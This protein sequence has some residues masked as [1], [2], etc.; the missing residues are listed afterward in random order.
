[1]ESPPIAAIIIPTL[2]EAAHI[3]PL[4]RQIIRQADDRVVE[5]IV[6]D[7]GSH[8]GTRRI[9]AAIGRE[10]PRVR[11]IDNLRRTQS[12]GL[13]IA[14]AVADP[15]ANV[16]V[17][18]DAHGAY[19]DDFVPRLLEA[20]VASG[21]QSVVIPMISVGMSCFQRAVAAVSNSVF[22]TGG[23]AHRIGGTSR[24]IDHGHHAAFDRRAFSAVGGYDE[25]FVANEDAELDVRLRAAGGR[26]WFASDIEMIY[27]PRSTA[28]G[29]AR[30][31]YNYGRGRA[32]TLRKHGERPR[33]RQLLPPVA[34]TA[35]ALALLLAPARPIALVVPAGYLAAVAAIAALLA[36]RTRDRCALA[37]VVAL[38]I[39]HLLWAAG[40]IGGLIQ[41]RAAA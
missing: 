5:I 41:P 3:E 16:L 24:F 1:M 23:A 12:A 35:I 6:A 39:I 20:L 2:N 29:L 19:P 9:V 11:L 7:G 40:L 36:A 10:E 37:A 32:R 18:I 22:G 4:L 25:S 13:N 26:I 14:A 15:R 27:Y 33:L 8:D 31:Y 28:R 17:R 38:P 34:L 21:G 30:Q